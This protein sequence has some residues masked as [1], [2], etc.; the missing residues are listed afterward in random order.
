MSERKKRVISGFFA[1]IG[2]SFVLQLSSLLIIPF[3]LELTSQE[4]FGLWLTLGAILGWIK[5]G[6]MGLGLSLTRRSVKALESR[7]YM[8][9]K[10]L[11]Y[12][13]ILTTTIFG[14]FISTIGFLLTDPLIEIFKVN[15][16]L[17]KDFKNTYLILLFI[18]VIRPSCFSL[19]SIIN[20]KQHLAFLHI[21]NTLI[22]LLS[23]VV[24]LVFLNLGF[25][26]SSFAFGLLFESILTPIVD[27]IYLK[28]IDKSIKF[29]PPTTTTKDIKSLLSFGAPYQALKIANLVSTNTDN[30]IIAAILGASSVTIYVFTGKLAFLLAIFLVSVIPSILFPGFSQLFEQ[31]NIAKIKKLYFRLSDIA[32]R[33]GLFSGISYLFINETFIELWVGTSNYGGAELTQIFVIWIIFESFIR[34]LTSIIYASSNLTGLTAVSFIEAAL[35]ILL[36]L[37]LIQ[38]MGLIG[39]VAGTVLS[40]VVTVIYIPMKINSIL[41]V[42]NIYFIKRLFFSFCRYSIPMLAVGIFIQNQLDNSINPFLR[43]LFICVPIF[44]INIFFEEGV[45]IYKQ[46]G[47]NLKDRFK[48]LKNN[49]YGL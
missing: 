38:N 18:A 27:Y 49:Y 14:C 35:N 26:I 12:G 32:I 22:S 7:D 25:G 4:L 11:T 36:T 47:L 17:E 8:L 15:D 1:S 19:S 45:F 44:F 33:L 37:I 10:R 13:T 42:K 23:I 16:N 28:R 30:I 6:D 20:A 46:K 39:V 40:R 29:S 34:G 48:S 3:Y 9:L 31:K 43:I 24:N 41:E 5:I 21:K 2:A